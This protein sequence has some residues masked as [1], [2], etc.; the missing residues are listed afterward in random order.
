MLIN[1]DKINFFFKSITLF[2]FKHLSGY[3]NIKTLKR[4]QNLST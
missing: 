2:N 3:K 1:F 4:E